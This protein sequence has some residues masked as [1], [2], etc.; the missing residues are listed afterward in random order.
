MAVECHPILNCDLS[1]YTWVSTHLHYDW[2][3]PAVKAVSLL[4]K[5]FILGCIGLLSYFL[6]EDKRQWRYLMA[7]FVF[8]AVLNQILKHSFM[9]CRPISTLWLIQ[10]TG[11]SFPSGHAQ[12]AAVMW[13]GLAYY[14]KSLPI[15]ITCVLIALVVCLSRIYLCVHFPSDVIG[16]FL[17]G[18]GILGI[19]IYLE[20]K[21]K[22][23]TFWF[24]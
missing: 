11:Y 4:G 10:E 23:N 16:G 20:K 2:L 22:R 13:M 8:S 7:A 3:T 17:I 24:F 18:L 14:L 1:F 12:G 9:T 6:F 5:G 21:L 15:R 19:T